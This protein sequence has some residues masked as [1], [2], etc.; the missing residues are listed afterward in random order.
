MKGNIMASKKEILEYY[1]NQ[2][3]TWIEI[4]PSVKGLIIPKSFIKKGRTRMTL[5]PNETILNDAGLE[6]KLVH[7]EETHEVKIPYTSIY[8]ATLEDDE[9]YEFAISFMDCFPQVIR[10]FFS[11]EDYETL[12]THYEYILHK[13]LNNIPLKE[14]STMDRKQILLDHL[15]I[16]KTMIAIDPTVKGVKLPKHLM[17]AD[18]VRLNLSNTFTY[19]MQ[20]KE[21]KVVTTL[22]FGGVPFECHIP[23]MSIFAVMIA[24][25]SPDDAVVFDESVPQPTKRMVSLY[26]SNNYDAMKFM[27]EL[28]EQFDRDDIVIGKYNDKPQ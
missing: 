27:A 18:T 14:N 13:I 24:G 22:T 10:D 20:F 6:T 11:E 21:D 12:H 26:E 25:T 2:G 4:N 8:L 17:D 15:A 16:A 5:D 7:E 1:L 3:N 9:S 28:E 19:P 23:Y